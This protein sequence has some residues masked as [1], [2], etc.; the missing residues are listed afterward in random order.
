MTQTITLTTGAGEVVFFKLQFNNVLDFFNNVE[1]F[2]DLK[3]FEDLKELQT[4]INFKI[5]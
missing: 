2:S 5:K 3:S 1:L 4:K